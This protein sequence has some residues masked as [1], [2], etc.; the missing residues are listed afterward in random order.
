MTTQTFVPSDENMSNNNRASFQVRVGIWNDRN[1]IA[2]WETVDS[3]S[4]SGNVRQVYSTHLNLA[5]GSA[6]WIPTPPRQV[7]H[8]VTLAGVPCLNFLATDT[9]LALGP[10]GTAYVVWRDALP[11]TLTGGACPSAGDGN[12]YFQRTTDYGNTWLATDVRL[13]T[14]PTTDVPHDAIQPSIAANGNTIYVSWSEIR[15]PTPMPTSPDRYDIY[16]NVSLNAG[17]SWQT[18]S[19]RVE[20]DGL[21]HD[22]LRPQMV[23]LTDQIGVVVWEDWRSGRPTARAN[24][25]TNAGVNWGSADY[26]AEAGGTGGPGSSTSSNIVA[27]G[28]AQSVFVVWQDDRDEPAT[29]STIQHY[30]IYSNFSLDSG[31]GFQ[32]QD[33]RLDN[34]PAGTDQEDPAAFT[35][36]N[37][38]HFAWT[39]RR[40]VTGGVAQ[41]DIYYRNMH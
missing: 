13:N 31:A 17:A 41:G 35:I 40:N 15:I 30:N 4:T 12:I 22:S 20:T 33:Y 28:A 38:G 37:V 23:A 21:K 29:A 11:R 2:V 26:P 1:A 32:P 36:N 7:T 16:A 19:T 25:T 3:T 24:R 10:N 27:V 5:S 39:D 14:Q 9:G 8:P 34:A 6:T 18:S